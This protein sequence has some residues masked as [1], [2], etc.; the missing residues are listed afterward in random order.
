MLV[1]KLSLEDLTSGLTSAWRDCVTQN[2]ILESYAS[3]AP[4]L[5]RKDVLEKFIRTSERI[6]QAIAQTVL[7]SRSRCFPGSGTSLSTMGD[8]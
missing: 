5:L 6:D 7:C 4:N 2:H 8:L 3:I 1:A